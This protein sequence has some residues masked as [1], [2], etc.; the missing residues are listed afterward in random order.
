MDLN[1]PE[2]PNARHHPPPRAIEV[3]DKRRVGG[4]VH[5]VVRRRPS[6]GL[7]FHLNGHPEVGDDPVELNPQPLGMY[8]CPASTA[9]D[10]A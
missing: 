3:D 2:Q 6:P 1:Q 5:A 10:G 4:R 9:Y 8:L 7:N